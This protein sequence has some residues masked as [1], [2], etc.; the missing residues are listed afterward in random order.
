MLR[1]IS[2]LLDGIAIKMMIGSL[3]KQVIFEY[4]KAGHPSKEAEKLAQA[5]MMISMAG[6][7]VNIESYEQVRNWKK[8]YMA[9]RAR[10]L[11]K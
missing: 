9:E 2:S 7:S 11:K 10:I 4:E 5:E 6:Q 3:Q 8:S 1:R